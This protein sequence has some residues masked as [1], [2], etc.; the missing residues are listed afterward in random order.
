MNHRFILPNH[1]LPFLQNALSELSKLGQPM[2]VNK[3]QIDDTLESFDKLVFDF[4][5]HASDI[6]SIGIQVGVLIQKSEIPKQIDKAAL[7]DDNQRRFDAGQ[8]DSVEFNIKIA[9]INDME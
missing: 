4:D 9:Q 1:F 3:L 7:L 8:I 5:A 2:I 6:L